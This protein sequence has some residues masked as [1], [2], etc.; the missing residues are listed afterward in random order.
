MSNESCAVTGLLHVLV[1]TNDLQKTLVFYKKIL[2]LREAQRPPFGFP[3]AWLGCPTPN[4]EL[5]IHVWAGGPGM[6]PEGVSPY[7]TATIDHVSLSAVGYKGFR[8]RFQRYGLDWREFVIP[9]TTLFQLF[10]YDPSGVQIE[11]TFDL[12]AEPSYNV[13]IDPA[14]RYS[15]GEKFFAL[16][17]YPDL[18]ARDVAA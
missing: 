8:D 15:A 11:L 18:V 14:H 1:K 13:D 10:V 3:G 17:T 5:V 12:G 7:G 2:G 4:G 9:N 6:G 16:A